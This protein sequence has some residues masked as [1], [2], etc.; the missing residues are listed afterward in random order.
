[1]QG[2]LVFNQRNLSGSGNIPLDLQNLQNGT[3]VL[4]LRTNEGIGT[5]RIVIQK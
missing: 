1:M 3:Y 5:S 4:I 2:R